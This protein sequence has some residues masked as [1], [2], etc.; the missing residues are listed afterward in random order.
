M[1]NEALY[2]VDECLIAN[3]GTVSDAISFQPFA[4][5]GFVLPAAFTGTAVSFQVSADGVTYV[6]LYDAT[7]TLV[8]IAVTQGRGY[9]FPIALFAFG[10]VKIVSNG[11][12]GGARTIQLGLKY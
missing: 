8:S 10:F 5:G 3:G 11:A 12:E 9:A 7:N 2:S 6:A 1:R 4:Q